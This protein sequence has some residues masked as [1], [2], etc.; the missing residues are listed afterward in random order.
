[1]GRGRAGREGWRIGGGRM[2]ENLSLQDRAEGDEAEDEDI[3]KFGCDG[4][5]SFRRS[6]NACDSRVENLK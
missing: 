6:M 1:V 2:A 3:G 4:E 5:R